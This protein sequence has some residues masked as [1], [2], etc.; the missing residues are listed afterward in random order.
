M[1]SSRFSKFSVALLLAGACF[2]SSCRALYDAKRPYQVY[3]K[4]ADYFSSLA[5]SKSSEPEVV[6]ENPDYPIELTLYKDKTFHYYLARLGDGTGSWEYRDGHL[7]LYAE[8]KL[9]V[10]Q[11]E[12]HS[13]SPD[14]AAEA[15]EEGK[16]K[17]EATANATGKA[18]ALEFSDRFGPK[19]L[20]LSKK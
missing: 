1:T 11:M 5:N 8:R 14:G 18:I 4:P 15:E 7:E 19:F 16:A 2:N 3:E 13:T 20:P 17:D 10:M 9:F 6:L 12:M